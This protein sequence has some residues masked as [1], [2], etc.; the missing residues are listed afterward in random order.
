ML[1][2][3]NAPIAIVVFLGWSM[4]S[5][6]YYRCLEHCNCFILTLSWGGYRFELSPN[7]SS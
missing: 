7:Y 2:V 5:N 6:G 3:N 4:F 1:P